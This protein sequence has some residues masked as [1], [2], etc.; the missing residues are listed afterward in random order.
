MTL[1]TTRLARGAG[2]AAALFLLNAS[3]AFENVWPTPWVTWRGAFSLE[4]AVAVAVLALAGARAAGA[5]AILAAVWVLL[6]FGRYADVTSSALFG[7]DINLYWDLR[8]IPDVASLFATAAHAGLVI[9]AVLVLVAAF[10]ALWFV[11]RWAFGRVAA[12]MADPWLR[13]AAALLAVIGM[14]AYLFQPAVPDYETPP[15]SFAR[16]VTA[17]YARQVRL[18]LAARAGGVSLPPTPELRSDLSRLGGADVLL[19]FLESYG[20]ISYDNPA[21][22]AR[23]AP[24]RE[25][26]AADIRETGREVVSAYVESPTFGGSSWLAHI[27]LLSGVDV[28]DPDTNALLMTTRRDTWPKAMARG[29]YRTIALMPGLWQRWPEGAFYGF[30]EI[31]GG[32]RL[33]YAGPPFGWFTIPDQF[34]LAK[35]DALEPTRARGPLFTFFPTISTH[36]PFTPTPPYQADWPRMLTDRPYDRAELDRVYAETPDWTNLGPSY[37]EAVAYSFATIGGYLRVH[38]D[39]DVVLV[40]LGDHQPPALVTGPGA[41]WDVPVHII[42]SRPAILERLRAAGFVPGLTPARPHLGRM[43]T[44]LPTLLAAFGD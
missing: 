5:V 38:P 35:F 11:V 12:A 40:L 22:A 29:G 4:L 28:H 2:L 34:A 17:T 27:S 30:D 3:L 26:L 43:N 14:A 9:A 19:I 7:R 23:L 13:A 6:V 24:D 10:A 25:R 15:Y 39:R 42:A 8:F 32:A 31:Y 1:S 18:A 21:F 16:P 20:A 37:T 44:L 41:P 33:D 36:T